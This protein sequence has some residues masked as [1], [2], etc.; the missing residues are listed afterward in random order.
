[1]RQTKQAAWFQ[2]QL[3]SSQKFRSSFISINNSFSAN[4]DPTTATSNFSCLLLPLG[5]S[6]LRQRTSFVSCF[7][8]QLISFTYPLWSVLFNDRQYVKSFSLP[9]VLYPQYLLFLANNLISSCWNQFHPPTLV[10]LIVLFQAHA[11]HFLHENPH[12]D[13]VEHV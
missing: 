13:P 5:I 12:S 8:V 2:L 9:A 11:S 3:S 7:C 4:F 6:V 1:M 10:F